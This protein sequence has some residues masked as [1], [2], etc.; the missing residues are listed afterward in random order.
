MQ[1]PDIN[2]PKRSINQKTCFP[3]LDGLPTEAGDM[4]ATWNLPGN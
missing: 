3:E 2:E 1:I 4:L